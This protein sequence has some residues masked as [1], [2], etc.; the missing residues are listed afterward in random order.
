MVQIPESPGALSVKVTQT[1][2]WKVKAVQ[3]T[4]AMN[5]APAHGSQRPQCLL[6]LLCWV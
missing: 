1:I 6:Q 2:I 3:C 4:L 5:V